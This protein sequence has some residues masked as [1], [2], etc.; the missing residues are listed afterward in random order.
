ME[1]GAAEFLPEQCTEALALGEDI[2]VEF[3]IRRLGIVVGQPMAHEQGV[4]SKDFFKLID[5]RNGTAF[6]KQNGV[7][8][9]GAA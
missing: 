5:D 2:E 6:A 4:R 8:V 3:L 9:E 1:S 7:P